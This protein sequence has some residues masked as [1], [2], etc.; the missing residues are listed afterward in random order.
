MKIPLS[1]QPYKVGKGK[2][3]SIITQRS[4]E[5][6]LTSPLNSQEIRSLLLKEGILSGQIVWRPLRN[7]TGRRLQPLNPT[8]LE[9]PA[10]RPSIDPPQL[11]CNL[12]RLT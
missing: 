9:V 6:T 10:P 11:P 2:S 12:P 7:P 8:G 1:T 5:S 4:L 3:T